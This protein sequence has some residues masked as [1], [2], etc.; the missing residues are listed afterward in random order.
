MTPEE[1]HLWYDF[2]KNY[3]IQ[4]YR[5]KVIGNYIVDFYCRR[6]KLAIEIDGAQHYEND[7]IEYDLR[8]T[9]YLNS[10]GI[11]V[12]RFLNG[13]VTRRFESVC[14]QIDLLVRERIIPHPSPNGDTFPKG[15]GTP[16]P[17]PN[18]D[19]FPKEEGS[20]HPPPNGDTVLLRC[21]KIS[22]ALRLEI[23]DRGAKPCSLLRPL[24]ALRKSCPKG[25]GSPHPPQSGGVGGFAA[26]K[27]KFSPEKQRS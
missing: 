12:L 20:H 7:A 27:R 15:E 11:A 25:E 8:R 9:E 24:D 17:S 1:K 18:G 2:L 13:D 19:T 4:F 3:E 5:Q 26:Q 22:A 6:A 21:P 14:A 10:E 23:F 16:H